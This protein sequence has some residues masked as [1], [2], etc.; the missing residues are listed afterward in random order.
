MSNN[1]PEIKNI[2]NRIKASA[3]KRNIPFNLSLVDLHYI[4]WPISCP[5]LRNSFKI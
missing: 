5:I 3:K 1:L 2:Y 4:G